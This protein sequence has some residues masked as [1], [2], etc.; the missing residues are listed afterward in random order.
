MGKLLGVRLSDEEVAL[1]EKALVLATLP[2]DRGGLSAWI[3]RVVLKEAL[4]VVGG[5]Q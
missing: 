4:R 1:L 2:G 3:R 5:G